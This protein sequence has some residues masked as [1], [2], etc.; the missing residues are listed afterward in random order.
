MALGLRTLAAAALLVL[1][2]GCA[3]DPD[4]PPPPTGGSGPDIRI[5][6]AS[7]RPPATQGQ[8]DIYFYDVAN[9]GAPYL[10][11]NANSAANES[12][13]AFSA[14]GSRMALMTFRSLIGSVA[15]LLLYDV[16]TGRL[17]VPLAINTLVG[18]NNPALSGDGR[19]LASHY[20]VG[21][22]FDLFV[23]AEDVAADT[24]LSLNGLNEPFAATFDP[25]LNGDG[26]LMV[27]ASNS[28]RSM[29]AFDILLYSVAA[30]SFLALPG[31]NSV[32]QELSPSISAD[33][34]Y[35][36]YQ[37]GDPAGVGIVDVY[38]YDRQTETKL[39]LPGANSV[40]SEYQP[41]ISADGRWLVYTTDSEGGGD[42]VLY[43]LQERKRVPLPGLN[44]PIY[45]DEFPVV[46]PAAG[47]SLARRVTSRAAPLAP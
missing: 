40:L 6:F 20:Q 44:D 16:P 23:A 22:P 15:S 25:Y 11:P 31:L 19:L 7:D 2:A 47:I 38:V 34:R 10:A 17:E 12:P 9:G 14:D 42:V 18:P 8:H 39:D 28:T 43:D 32:H 36:A 35:V 30:D 37:S 21:G 4:D 41:T 46:A 45:R 13:M 3:N 5:A 1:L 24:L 27:V 33:G 29:G 26:S